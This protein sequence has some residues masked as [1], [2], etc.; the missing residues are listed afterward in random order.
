MD[1]RSD[2][3]PSENPPEL[4]G[5]AWIAAAFVVYVALGFV[6]KAPVLNWIVGPLWLLATLHVLPGLGRRLRARFKP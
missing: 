5:R 3:Q 2:A 1:R 6:L 4:L